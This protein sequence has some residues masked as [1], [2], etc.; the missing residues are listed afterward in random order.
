MLGTSAEAIVLLNGGFE[1]V[2]GL[3]LAAGFF[4]RIVALILALH[5]FALAYE[6]GYNDIGVRDFVLGIATLSLCFFGPDQ[7]TIDKRLNRG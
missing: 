5:V 3:L 1:V 6:I 7:Y 4:T 2:F